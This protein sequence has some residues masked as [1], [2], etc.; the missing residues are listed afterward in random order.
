MTD[1]GPGHCPHCKRSFLD[2]DE[3]DVGDAPRLCPRCDRVSHARCNEAH[4][5]PCEAPTDREKLAA[6]EL[7]CADGKGK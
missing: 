2:A 5:C 3:T 6:W 1:E 4:A 7:G